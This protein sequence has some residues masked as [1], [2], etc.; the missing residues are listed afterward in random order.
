MFI[1]YD[2]SVR[3]VIQKYKDL[4]EESYISMQDGHRNLLKSAV[5]SFYQAGHRDQALRIFYDLRSLYPREEFNV[6]LDTFAQNLFQEQLKE[7]GL[8]NA[9]M[10]IQMI[11]VEAYFRYSMH[12]DDDAFAKERLASQAYDYYQQKYGDEARVAL[13]EFKHLKYLSFIDFWFDPQY[14]LVLKESL[15]NRIEI[16]RPDLYKELLNLEEELIKQQEQKKKGTSTPS[17]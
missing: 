6:S 15:K 10:M 13:P 17:L 14:P 8:T 9:S 16:E 11:L 7:I 4:G 5:L 12:D 1:P 3:A 2:R